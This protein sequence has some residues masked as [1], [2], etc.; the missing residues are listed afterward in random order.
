MSEIKHTPTTYLKNLLH[1]AMYYE[2]V[3]E[4]AQSIL[5]AWI[6]PDSKITDSEVLSQLLEILDAQDLVKLMRSK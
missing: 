2:S 3:L 1:R 5:A 6:V 4:D